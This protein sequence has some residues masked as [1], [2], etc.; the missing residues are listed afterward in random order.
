M[1]ALTTTQQSARADAIRAAG[2]VLAAARAHTAALPAEQVAAL[3]YVPG[4][5]T[6]AELTARVTARRAGSAAA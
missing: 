2:H 3:A 6:V 4:G 1:A 5:P